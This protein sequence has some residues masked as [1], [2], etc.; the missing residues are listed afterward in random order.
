MDYEFLKEYEERENEAYLKEKDLVKRF[1]NLKTPIFNRNTSNISIWSQITFSGT[2]IFPLHPLPQNVFETEHGIK[3][4]QFPELIQ[5]VK[6]MNKVQFVLTDA[7]TKYV[8]YDYLEP[9]LK[10]FEPPIYYLSGGFNQ[11][12]YKL[13]LKCKDEIKYLIQYS[14]EWRFLKFLI[15]TSR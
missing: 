5:F 11:E 15:K 6:D 4:T 9:L 13:F 10:E 12:F 2:L 7:P 1:K 3:S 14:P 8:K